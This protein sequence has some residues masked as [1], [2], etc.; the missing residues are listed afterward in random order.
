MFSYFRGS[1]GGLSDLGWCP[2]APY[3][4]RLPYIWTPPYVQQILIGYLFCYFIKCFPTLE[5][6]MQGVV[7]LRSVH[8]PPMFIHPIHLDTPNIFRKFE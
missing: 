3:V 5:T 1:H 6:V 4:H 7:R 8:M 2:Y